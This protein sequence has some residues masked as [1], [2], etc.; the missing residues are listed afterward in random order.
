MSFIMRVHVSSPDAALNPQILTYAEYRIFAVLSHYP[1]VRAARVVLHHDEAARSVRCS[2]TIEHSHGSTRGRVKGAHA[3]DTIDRTAARVG[4]L[5]RRR[6]QPEMPPPIAR[7][8]EAAGGVI[9]PF[10]RNALREKARVGGT[11]AI[12][13]TG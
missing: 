11:P 13:T 3:A 7:T 6:F 12:P 2:V 9:R 5:M 10:N 8:L 1:E 4:H